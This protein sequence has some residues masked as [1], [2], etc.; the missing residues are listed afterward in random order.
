[1]NNTLKN[2]TNM[3]G[4]VSKM[5]EDILQKYTNDYILLLNDYKS[6]SKG[7]KLN[8]KF[9]LNRPWIKLNNEKIDI[10]LEHLKQ[11]LDINIL[12]NKFNQVNE[13]ISSE[14]PFKYPLVLKKIE[15]SMFDLVPK[16]FQINNNNDNFIVSLNN[17]EL[18]LMVRGFNSVKPT[19]I[20]SF[21]S[22]MAGTEGTQIISE[23]EEDFNGIK[24]K[25]IHTKL[26]PYKVDLDDSSKEKAIEDVKSE[27]SRMDVAM[28]QMWRIVVDRFITLAK[29]N[30][31]E[32]GCAYI[33]LEDIYFNYKKGKGSGEYGTSIPK[34]VREDYMK[35]FRALEKY[36]VN[37]D[38]SNTSNRLT[39]YMGAKKNKKIISNSSLFKIV[40]IMIDKTISDED[41]GKIIEDND[42]NVLGFVY[43]LG[44]IG[45]IYIEDL[46]ISK[47]NYRYSKDLLSLN[48]NNHKV[49]Y[50]IGDFLEY[51]HRNRVYKKN[52]E[53]KFSLAKLVE[54]AG[55]SINPSRFKREMESLIKQLDIASKVLIDNGKIEDIS[56]LTKM[57]PKYK[58]QLDYIYIT[59]K[60]KYV[61]EDVFNAEK[62][63]ADDIDED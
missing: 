30:R 11:G 16:S 2:K 33:S 25:L 43:Q 50:R 5:I 27:I 60:F 52:K 17:G 18:N 51:H 31:L 32:K 21:G 34:K 62:E 15:D 4:G 9:I 41:D 37:I 23:V 38:Y 39:T 26:L 29:E 12:E 28:Q 45:K 36:S 46:S 40:D 59:V 1:M 53:F 44:S 6:N 22:K 63:D 24:V 57:T 35:I 48:N 54:V 14:K 56:Y 7:N 3:S 19:S 61:K 47:F 20:E 10:N 55:I 13:L 49:A 58:N 42:S 8:T